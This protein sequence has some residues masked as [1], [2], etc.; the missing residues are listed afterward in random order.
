MKV[1]KY[2]PQTITAVLS[3]LM[4]IVVLLSSI[5]NISAFPFRFFEK[6]GMYFNN[7]N[8][9]IINNGFSFNGT[10]EG[11]VSLLKLLSVNSVIHYLI[12][13]TIFAILIV[14]ALTVISNS[15]TKSNYKWTVYLCAVLLP[16][17][18]CDF[19][20]LAYFKTLYANPLIVLG[21]LV[22]LLSK[23]TKNKYSKIISVILG[24]VVILQSVIFTFSYKPYDYKQNLYN[25]VFYGV[26]KYDSVTEIGLDKKLDDLLRNEGK[27][28]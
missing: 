2:L 7:G 22:I 1:K 23:I 27:R 14:V 11:F 16:L 8:Y 12:P 10:Y 18:F 21:V 19:A 4:L 26:A 5:V 24:A 13:F 6:L 15:A 17:V 9:G 3:A 28:G 20:N 25:S